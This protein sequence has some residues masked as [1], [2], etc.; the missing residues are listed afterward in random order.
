MEHTHF[1]QQTQL[2]LLQMNENKDESNK[3]NEE[4]TIERVIKSLCCVKFFFLGA[5]F[6]LF[7]FCFWNISRW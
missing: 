1:I 2:R 4:K 6:S 7:L 5:K 3:F